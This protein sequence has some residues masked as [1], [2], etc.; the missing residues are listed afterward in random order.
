MIPESIIKTGDIGVIIKPSTLIG[1]LIGLF[2]KNKSHSFNLVREYGELYTYE[3]K[4]FGVFRTLYKDWHGKHSDWVLL[5]P[6][7]PYNETQKNKAIAFNS[8]IYQQHFTYDVSSL[9]KHAY[10][11]ASN[12]YPLEKRKDRA[13]IC[14]ELS[15]LMANYC[16]P[17]TFKEPES[18]TPLDLYKSDFYTHYKNN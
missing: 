5:S 16:Q 17:Y 14:S 13:L 7:R 15:A 3:M 11:I 8:T 1:R 18:V 2:T 9:L 12:S 6:K 4:G 10:K